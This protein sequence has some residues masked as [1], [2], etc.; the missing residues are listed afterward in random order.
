MIDVFKEMPTVT[1]QFVVTEDVYKGFQLCSGDMNPLHTQTDF[2]KSKGFPE[3]VMYGNIL[4]AFVSTLIGMY[5]PIPDVIIHSQDIQY[6]R[7]VFLNDILDAELRVDEIFE[8]VNA[9][10]FKF[11]FRNQHGQIVSK[12]HVQIG[13]I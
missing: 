11:I 8:S 7:P 1:H 6:K 12:G 10:V 5:L 13:V 2:A 4:N 3:C 9:V